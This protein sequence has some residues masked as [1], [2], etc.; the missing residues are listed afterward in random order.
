MTPRTRK[1][2]LEMIRDL[3]QE[4]VDLEGEIADAKSAIKFNINDIKRIQGMMDS[5]ADVDKS[6]LGRLHEIIQKQGTGYERT[7]VESAYKGEDL[8]C[9]D[10][11]RVRGLAVSMIGEVLEDV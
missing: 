4:N 1:Q 2:A 3:Q 8:D 7:I 6:Q 10:A 9:R 11:E 5:L